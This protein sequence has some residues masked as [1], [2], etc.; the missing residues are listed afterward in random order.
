MLGGKNGGVLQVKTRNAIG[1]MLHPNRY[2]TPPGSLLVAEN[3]VIDREGIVSKRRGFERYGSVLSD[4]RQ[5]FEYLER[6]VVLDG[7]TLKYDTD[8]AGTWGSWTGSFSPP[9]A[10]TPMRALESNGNFYFT[11]DE[12][13]FVNDSLTGTPRL[14]GMPAGLDVNSTL[15]HTGAGWMQP[16]QWGYRMVWLTK[17]ANRNEKRGAPSFRHIVYNPEAT[18]LAWTR[19]LAVI[20]VTE[21]GH[22]YAPGDKIIVSASSDLTTIPL[23]EYTITGVAGNDYTFT[24]NNAGAANGTLSKYDLAFPTLVTTVP[25]DV[26]AGDFL[27]IYR[28]PQSATPSTDPGDRMYL[29][30]THTVTAGDLAAG[31]VTWDDVYDDS[32]LD[33]PLY[34][35]DTEEGPASGN[36]RPPFAKAIAAYKNHIWYLNTR[37][38]HAKGLQALTTE[39]IGIGDTLTI[40]DGSVTVVVE[41][42]AAENIAAGEFYLDSTSTLEQERLA[43]TLQSI[44]RVINR[45]A[46]NT[47]VYAYYVSGVDDPAGKIVIRRRDFLDTAFTVTIA[48]ATGWEDDWSPSLATGLTSEADVKLNAVYRSK[49]GQPEAVPELSFETLGRADKAGL[50]LSPLQVSMLAWKE[51]GEF[52]V[53]GESDGSLGTLFE[54]NELDPTAVLNAPGATCLL[55]NQAAGTTTQGINLSG[56]GGGTIVSRQIEVELNRLSKVVGFATYTRLIGYD[57][58]RKLLALIH[59]D[60]EMGFYPNVIYVYNYATN[61]WTTWTI[62]ARDGLVLT[63]D[64]K[65]YLIHAVDKYVLKERKTFSTSGDDFKDWSHSVTI[66]ATATTTWKRQTVTQVT[67]TSAVQPQEG[68]RLVQGGNAAHVVAATLSGASWL[69]TL[70]DQLTLTAPGAASLERGI[71]FRVQWLPD[72]ADAEG[73]LKRFAVTAVFLEW[74]GGTYRMAFRS[75]IQ[76]DFQWIEDRRVVRTIGW[77]SMPWGS[78]WGGNWPGKLQSLRAYLPRDQQI[79]RS[80]SFQLENKYAKQ[81]CPVLEIDHEVVALSDRTERQ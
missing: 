36:A 3:A 27:E 76:N 69:V 81:D 43:N 11:T 31:T 60:H 53:S 29:V 72:D 41:A 51:D 15:D 66:T 38:E 46:G 77:G 48:S 55:N 71:H 47:I 57:S 9:D 18:G 37:R 67:L 5:C 39:H 74:A 80:L 17:D 58:D 50:S 65:L 78:A 2:Q 12:G 44:V 61:A 13:V 6:L 21:A 20:T 62:P 35:N 32:Y 7:S 28:T 64:D 16:G 14:A 40:S 4:P 33:L 30:F 25:A 22:P 59:D 70:D 8:L 42:A 24:A 52:I 26:Q 23:G 19:A 56:T 49:F 45:V 1:L 54:Y 68:W 34:T 73:V 10:S 79:G 75:D 63:G